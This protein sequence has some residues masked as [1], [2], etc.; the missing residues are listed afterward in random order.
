M[1]NRQRNAERERFWRSALKRQA[2]SGLSV[3]AF[4][5]R[6]GLSEPSLYAWRTTVARRDAEGR[7]LGSRHRPAK[8]RQPGTAFVPVVV[9]GSPR[10]GAEIV[11]ELV[12]GRRLRLPETMGVE[13]VARLV[14]AIEA[15]PHAREA[16]G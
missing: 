7:P 9:T 15:D 3:R 13:E 12:G 10:C 16:A 14:R 4:C 2:A 11:L 8:M 1:A 6:E 5:R